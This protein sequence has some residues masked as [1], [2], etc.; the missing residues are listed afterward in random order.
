MSSCGEEKTAP[1]RLVT[2]HDKGHFFAGFCTKDWFCNSLYDKYRLSLQQSVSTPGPTQRL[3]PG[4]LALFFREMLC[5]SNEDTDVSSSFLSLFIGS[6]R[7]CLLHSPSPT[8]PPAW[9]LH[10]SRFDLKAVP[11]FLFK[12]C[13]SNIKWGLSV[14]SA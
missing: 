13:L 3:L 10:T 14:K 7:A 8:P 1:N 4:S 5:E 12:M 9:L 11:S 2:V 6:S